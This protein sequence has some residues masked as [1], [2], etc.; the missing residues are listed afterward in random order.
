MS[1]PGFLS[2]NVE[3][4]EAFKR[5]LDRAK[6]EVSDLRPALKSIAADFYRSQK[7]IFNL[8]GPGQFEPFKKSTAV[9]AVGKNGKPGKVKTLKESPYQKRKIKEFG[10]DY[11]LLKAGGTLEESVTSPS[12]RGAI[13]ILEKQDVTIGTDVPYAKYHQSDKPR[14]KIPLRKFLFIGAEG[15]TDN[16]LSGRLP[17]WMNILNTY[18]LR[19]MGVSADNAKGPSNG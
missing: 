14:K 18:V 4:D 6:A 5:A 10:F 8:R 9:Q 11:P 3:Q 1:T 12:G 13:Y 17:R 15:W 19:S 2:F 16:K 7:A